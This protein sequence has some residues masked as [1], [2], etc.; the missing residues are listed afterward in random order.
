MIIFKEAKSYK[1]HA[2]CIKSLTECCTRII[3]K[4]GY[5]DEDT[6]T[7]TLAN[8]RSLAYAALGITNLLDS[9]STGNETVRRVIP[10]LLGLT[11]IN[12]KSVDLMGKDLAKNAKLSL[13]TLSQFQIENCIANL[14]KAL[15]I[16]NKMGFYQKVSDLVKFLKLDSGKLETLNTGALIRNSLHSN[17]IHRGYKGTSSSINLKGVQYVF[18]N[19]NKVSCASM[20]HIAQK[21]RAIKSPSSIDRKRGWWENVIQRYGKQN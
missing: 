12:Q 21:F 2:E 13:I 16:K 18:D 6:R 1:D 7:I 5:S 14:S 3:I 20:S 9:W 17:G 15:G 10:K 19:G 4:H 11:D 8:T